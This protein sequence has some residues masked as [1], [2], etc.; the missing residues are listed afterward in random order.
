MDAVIERGAPGQMA[1]AVT[2]HN[3]TN[4]ADGVCRGLYIGVGGNIVVV[5]PQGSAVTFIG[6]VAGTILPVQAIRVNSTSTTA[7]SIVA[8]Y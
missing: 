6:V 4:F 8:I 1:V 7:A 5:P 3:S 2:P